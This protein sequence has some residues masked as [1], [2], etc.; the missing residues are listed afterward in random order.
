MGAT[1]FV[2]N[3]EHRVVICR[4]CGTCLAPGGPKAWKDHLGRKP[5]WIKGD[6][7]R[8]TVEL[9]STYDLRGKEELRKWRPGRRTPY[10]PI[11]AL[12]ERRGYICLY[13]TET[14]DFVTTRLEAIHGHIPRHGV[15]ASQHS[16]GRPL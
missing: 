14:Y 1:D 6:E 5:H 16:Q 13:E 10:E 11:K 3:A 4:K 15:K 9:L 8:T 12:A 7:L 2:Y